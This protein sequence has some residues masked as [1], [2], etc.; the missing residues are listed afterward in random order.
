M[1]DVSLMAAGL[2]LVQTT[3]EAAAIV[4]SAN[5]RVVWSRKSASFRIWLPGSSDRVDHDTMASA[6]Y[7]RVETSE[8]PRPV[9]FEAWMSG[10]RRARGELLESVYRIDSLEQVVSLLW[11]VEDDRGDDQDDD[12]SL[13]GPS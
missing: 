13:N 5:G 9:P 4:V 1:Y 7:R 12:D 6:A 8:E 11:H 3:R 10:A 2:R